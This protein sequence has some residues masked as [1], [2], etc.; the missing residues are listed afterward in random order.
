MLSVVDL[1]EAGTLSRDLAAYS[2]AAIGGGAS[3]LVG[4]VPGGAGKTTV[5]AA[6]LNFV[7]ADVQLAA[8]D[9]LA[10]IRQAIKSPRPRR[11]YICHEIGRGRYYAYLWGEEVQ[12]YFELP[13]AGHMIATNLHADTCRQAREQIV[14]ECGVSPEALRR[15][16]LMYFLS[17]RGGRRI[18]HVDESDGTGEHKLVYVANTG[19]TPAKNSRLVSER[20]IDAA[21]RIIDK[22]VASGARTIQE[23][24]PAVL[25]LRG[26]G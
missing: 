7:P 6:L 21:R 24:R 2:L 15:V 3:F 25:E 14:G 19:T 22:L 20:Q 5:M 10:T 8:A 11:C 16:N 4:A 9:S 23:V 13:T 26:E 1:I 12:A 18:D 17:V